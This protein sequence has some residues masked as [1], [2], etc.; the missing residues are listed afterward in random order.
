MKRKVK[1]IHHIT[2]SLEGKKAREK[3]KR[4]NS[5]RGL[6]SSE[7]LSDGRK[8]V[9]KQAK[10]ITIPPRMWTFSAKPKF[11]RYQK[12]MEKNLLIERVEEPKMN[13]VETMGTLVIMAEL[14][15]VKQG[16]IHWEINDDIFSLRAQDRLGSRKYTKEILLPFV[17]EK[18]HI[19]TGYQEG[20]FEIMF[21]AKK[22]KKK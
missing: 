17:V 15:E 3:K 10:E 8:G 21:C 18:S 13:V 2:T 19:H 5:R 12:S 11:R 16:D 20:I 7:G 22:E 1:G 14:P 4:L 9:F 6:V